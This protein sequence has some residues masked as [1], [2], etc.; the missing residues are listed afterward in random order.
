VIKSARKEKKDHQKSSIKSGK[1][2]YSE[3]ART[4]PI[5]KT[6]TSTTNNEG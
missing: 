2:N 1:K 4:N 6:T 3:F 5:A